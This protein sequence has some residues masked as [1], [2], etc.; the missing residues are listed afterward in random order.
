MISNEQKTVVCHIEDE[1]HAKPVFMYGMMIAKTLEL[2]LLLLNTITHKHLPIKTD[3]SGN[4]GLGS[5]D[6]LLDELAKA[7]QIESRTS[8]KNGRELLE[9][10]KL[11]AMQSN[12]SDI[13][14][15]QKHGDLYE[16]IKEYEQS[17]RLLIVGCSNKEDEISS[18][19]KDIV[20]NLKIPTLLIKSDFLEPKKVMIA[21]DGSEGATKAL[22]TV[23]KTPLFR[24]IKRYIVTVSDDEGK[25]SMILER[26]SLLLKAHDIDAESVFLEGEIATKLLEFAESQN[27]D[28][29]A[30]GAFSHNRLREIFLG[31]L[32]SRMIEQSKIPILLLR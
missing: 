22:E 16:N 25:A 27:I 15:I 2:P 13:S 26:A 24:D 6:D 11:L 4:I 23:A 18:Q 21:Y 14:M 29:L 31:S 7:E 12:F 28:I 5:S 1:A 20:R 19:T 10:L 32:T 30:M 3:L 17:V 8:I 9:K